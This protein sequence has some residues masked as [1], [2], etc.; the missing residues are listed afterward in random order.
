M[1]LM[2][3]TPVPSVDPS[4]VAELSAYSVSLPPMLAAYTPLA[5]RAAL[6]LVTSCV[7]VLLGL[8]ATVITM[9]LMLKLLPTVRL[10]GAR[11]PAIV[12]QA[13][14]HSSLPT[15]TQVLYKSPALALS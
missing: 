3:M 10:E 6:M 8:A 1:L 11:V 5:L 4:L 14:F 15:S 7:T 9:S 2:A 13:V 12:A